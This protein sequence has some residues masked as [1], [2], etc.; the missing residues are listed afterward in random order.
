MKEIASIVGL[1]GRRKR[2]RLRRRAAAVF[3]RALIH[4]LNRR[5]HMNQTH[6]HS[7]SSAAP[8][9]AIVS[10]SWHADLVGRCREAA[11]R[12]LE[13]GGPV[14][15]ETFEVPG[16]F[17][18]PLH[19]MKLAR[20]G[21]F[22]AVLACAL[23]VDGGIYR[24]DF[25]AHAVIDGLMRVQLD[26]GVPVFSAVLTP[27]AFHEHATHH[28]F[29]HEHLVT[30]GTELASACRATLAALRKLDALSA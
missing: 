30:K 28:G 3:V 25:V 8:R 21:Q 18:I 6:L 29:F 11:I 19:A 4:R 2:S 14:R 12:A 16:A 15:V 20:S 5:V 1:A 24:H 13:A 26:T 10:A 17:E 9:V 23:V 22:D 27:L 7:P